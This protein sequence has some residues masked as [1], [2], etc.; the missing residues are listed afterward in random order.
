MII[1]TT[2]SINIS[3]NESNIFWMISRGP[4]S[5]RQSK[6]QVQITVG[7]LDSQFWSITCFP[8]RILTLVGLLELSVGS[9]LDPISWTIIESAILFAILILIPNHYEIAVVIRTKGF[10]FVAEH[11]DRS[12]VRAVFDITLVR[13]KK[14]KKLNVNYLTLT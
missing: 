4:A 14:L 2:I 5:A 8:G 6:L 13:P 10:S 3:T 9:L 12:R 11:V 7:R 1:I